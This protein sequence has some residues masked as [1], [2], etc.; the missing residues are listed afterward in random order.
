MGG[1]TEPLSWLLVGHL[2]GDYLVQTSWMANNKASQ[3]LPLLAHVVVYTA[4]VYLFSLPAGGIGYSGLALILI[5]HVILDH[6]RVVIWW[7]R[8]VCQADDIP[9]MAVVVDQSWHALV[10]ALASLM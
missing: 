10:L 5:A 9:W 6:R 1:Q 4:C 3:W 7:V 2:V 8:T